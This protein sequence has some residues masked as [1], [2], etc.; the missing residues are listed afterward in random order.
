MEHRLWI[1]TELCRRLEASGFAGSLRAVSE[2]ATCRRRDE[3][4]GHVCGAGLSARIIARSMPPERETGSAQATLIN[5]VIERAHARAHY[6]REVL[7]RF[8][9]MMRSK[10]EARPDP[11]RLRGRYQARRLCR[12]RRG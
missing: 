3:T 2:W 11:N 1:G 7:D 10:D 9:A 5:A 4:L 6:A 8:H 12:W